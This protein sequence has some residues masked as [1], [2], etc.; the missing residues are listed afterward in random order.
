MVTPTDSSLIET[1][2]LNAVDLYAWLA[3]VLACLPDQIAH[4]VADRRLGKRAT[5]MRP[6]SLPHKQTRWTRHQ[7]RRA[8]LGGVPP[9][10]ALPRASRCQVS[11][12]RGTTDTT[13]SG[14]SEPSTARAFS[15]SDRLRLPPVI[16][17]VR[18]PSEGFGSNVK[19]SLHTSR[20][21][22]P[23]QSRPSRHRAK[24]GAAEHRL[25]TFFQSHR[26]VRIN[27]YGSDDCLGGAALYRS[28]V[29]VC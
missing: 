20:S 11:N 15:S 13:A 17:S 2:Q 24:N 9:S 10:C 1:C 28:A 8:Q 18:R 12:C 21:P 7:S 22:N 23:D 3:D 19:S 26:S 29:Q 4:R 6:L 25:R 27:Y 5:T 14:V 16:T